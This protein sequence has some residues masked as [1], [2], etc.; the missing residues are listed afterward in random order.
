MHEVIANAIEWI[1][2]VAVFDLPPGIVKTCP[3][4]KRMKSNI[5]YKNIN[6]CIL[7]FKERNKIS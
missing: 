5:E 3:G 6:H 4:T 1:T 7:Y 2:T